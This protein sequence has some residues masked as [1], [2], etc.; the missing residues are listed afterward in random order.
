MCKRYKMSPSVYNRTSLEEFRR[1]LNSSCC[2]RGTT[3]AENTARWHG[4]QL[5]FHWLIGFDFYTM[6]MYLSAQ[7]VFKAYN[8]NLFY[9]KRNNSLGLSHIAWKLSCF[10]KVVHHSDE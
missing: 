6:F 1:D 8:F 9:E 3:R 4:E 10:F 5:N 2:W 7:N